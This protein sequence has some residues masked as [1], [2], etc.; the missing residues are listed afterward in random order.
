MKKVYIIGAGG[1]ASELT[2]YIFQ[3]NKINNEKIEILGYFDKDEELYNSY[4]YEKPYL[5][6]EKEYSFNEGDS[7]LIAIGNIEIRKNLIVYFD[8]IKVNPIN[9]IHYTSIVA[10]NSI[11]GKG[12][13]ICPYVVIGPNTNI[14]NFNLINYYC[15][16]PHD[17]SIGDN[18]IF[19]PN[20][21][22]TGFTKI[23]NDNLFGV[24]TGTKPNVIMGDN[25]KIQPGIIV[26]KNI[27]NNM[28]VFN[29]NKI[30]VMEL[31]KK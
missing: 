2:E 23:G 24:S 6:N 13:I 12:N 19:S 27:N 3:N 4:S 18:N 7:V 31:Y 14:G 17:N 21:Q 1:F 28:L 25:N 22:L 9:F 8:E 20:C 16:I 29:L 30:K 10:N 11:I 5:G 15:G 26:D